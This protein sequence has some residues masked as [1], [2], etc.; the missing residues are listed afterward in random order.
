LAVVQDPDELGHRV[1]ALAAVQRCEARDAGHESPTFGLAS[2]DAAAYSMADLT[3][4]VSWWR[5]SITVAAVTDLHEPPVLGST[6]PVSTADNYEAAMAQLLE[7]TIKTYADEQGAEPERI[8]AARQT[9]RT[10]G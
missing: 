1:D 4:S 10:S 3:S 6:T 2:V 9:G 5:S 8:V 7:G